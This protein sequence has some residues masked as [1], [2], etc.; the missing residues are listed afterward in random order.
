VGADWTPIQNDKAM[1]P[2]QPFLDAGTATIETAGSL[3]GGKRVWMLAKIQSPDMVIVPRSDDR[4]GKY[5]VV[6][7]GHDGSLAFLMGATPVRVV[8][9]NTLSIAIDGKST[10][11]RIPHTK[12]GPAAVAE[13]QKIMQEQEGRFAAAAEVF[14]ALAGKRIRRAAD[15][16]A[17]IDAVFPQPARAIKVAKEIEAANGPTADLQDLLKKPLKR[18]GKTLAEDGITTEE[19]KR[20]IYGEIET[21]FQK[22]RGNDLPG[23]KGTAWGLYNATTEY[24][25][26]E[27][28]GENAG[29]SRLDNVWLRTGS[30]PQ[31]KALPAAIDQFLKN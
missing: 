27:R 17:Y 2:F 7:C 10:F 8:C 24:L 30:G 12:G 23:V 16:R 18:Q 4:V 3:K 28:G 5:M 9:N 6:A 26:W 29:E 22:G 31:S 14:R 25:T 11:I 15:V 13:V 20:R 19:T 21:L 1:A